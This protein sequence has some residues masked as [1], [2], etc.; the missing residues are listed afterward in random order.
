MM[1]ASYIPGI[2]LV[3]LGADGEKGVKRIDQ[4]VS[5]R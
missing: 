1:F 5:S 4:G 3:H 2:L